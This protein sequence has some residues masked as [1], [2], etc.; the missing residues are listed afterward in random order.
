MKRSNI[1]ENPFAP[2]SILDATCRPVLGKDGENR[3]VFSVLSKYIYPLFSP[4]PIPA[5][6]GQAIGLLSPDMCA[7]KPGSQITLAGTAYAPFGNMIREFQIEIAAG[8]SRHCIQVSGPRKIQRKGFGFSF[9][10]PT[11]ISSL[12]LGIGY[13]FGGESLGF[14]YPPNP[15]GQGF[16]LHRNPLDIHGKPL[17]CLEHPSQ[18]LRPEH[19]GIRDCK[20][21]AT[22]PTPAHCGFL[23]A[24]FHPRSLW[25]TQAR[26]DP[27]WHYTAPQELCFSKCL[28]P[29]TVISIR[30]C[31]PTLPL[32]QTQLPTHPPLVWFQLEGS[33]QARVMEIQ[34]VH[35]DLTISRITV[36]WRASFLVP[37]NV[38][39]TDSE[40]LQFGVI[41]PEHA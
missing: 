18:L 29:G 34:D 24:Q 6:N 4:T 16:H 27:R 23:P 8:K 17:P 31:H 13:S 20:Q 1:H 7:W 32:L 36:L 14:N 30:N 21:W 15:I 39:T 12:I 35:I 10:D 9:T 33:A 5:L 2:L 38:D 19:I 26:P 11:P 25:S 28:P 41:P 37:L 22:L 40:Q 3:K